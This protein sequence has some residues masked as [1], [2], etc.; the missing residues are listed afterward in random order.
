MLGFQ[1]AGA[2]ALT[3]RSRRC[4]SPASALPPPHTVMFSSKTCSR[5]AVWC[6]ACLKQAWQH[7]RPKVLCSQAGWGTL[8]Y[9]LPL[10]D[11]LDELHSLCNRVLMT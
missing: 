1:E 4:L 8:E 5:T 6:S 10:W 11:K 2:S 7:M 9:C 3:S